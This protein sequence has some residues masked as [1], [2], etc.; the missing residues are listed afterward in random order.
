MSRMS[1]AGQGVDEGIRYERIGICM[2]GMV[3]G[4]NTNY[5]E[6]VTSN[7]SPQRTDFWRQHDSSLQEHPRGWERG[8]EEV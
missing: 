8:K 4:D 5:K 1:K 3:V 6:W 7:F 2:C